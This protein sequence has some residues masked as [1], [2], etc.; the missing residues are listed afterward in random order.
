MLL[1]TNNT[2]LLIMSLVDAS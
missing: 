2:K 1:K